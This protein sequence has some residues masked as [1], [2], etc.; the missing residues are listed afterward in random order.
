MRV[1]RRI[2]CGRSHG[3]QRYPALC[4]ALG[5]DESPP[6]RHQRP[7]RFREGGSG[8][9]GDAVEDSVV[10]MHLFGE[11]REAVVVALQLVPFELLRHHRKVDARRTPLDRKLFVDAA[12]FRPRADEQLIAHR[13][14]KVGLA[15]ERRRWHLQ[16][17]LMP[18]IMHVMPR[19]AR[20]PTDETTRL[21]G[22]LA[23]HIKRSGQTVNRFALSH[24]IEQYTLSRFLS[25]RTKNVTPRMRAF[26]HS[27]H[28]F[29]I[30]SITAVPTKQDNARLAAAVDRACA[31]NPRFGEALAALIEV[32][33][34]APT[35]RR[36]R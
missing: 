27:L 34:D 2:A 5:N 25:G 22:A 18:L 10:G 6:R 15:N 8:D 24:G 35:N 4:G 26:L 17:T 20:P 36:P 7:G 11:S 21:R 13:G 16:G 33:L 12:A 14:A 9:E 23:R 19:M 30:P 1:L 3:D 29:S 32:M 28:N 31:T